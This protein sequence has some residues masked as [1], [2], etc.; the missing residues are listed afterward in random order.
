L[1]FQWSASQY[2]SPR[3]SLERYRSRKDSSKDIFHINSVDKDDQGNYI[4]LF[5]YLQ[6]IVCV[7]P[8]GDVLWT[9]GGKRNSFYDLSSGAATRI[10][11]EHRAK[12]QP[13]NI[14]N[15]FE[16]D[17]PDRRASHAA[18]HQGVRIA[19]D[20]DNITAVLI[21]ESANSSATFVPTHSQYSPRPTSTGGA[22]AGSSKHS[23]PYTESSPGNVICDAALGVYETDKHNSYRKFKGKWTG[24]P[25]RRPDVAI[26]NGFTDMNVYVSWNGATDV[27]HWRVESAG[28]RPGETMIDLQHRGHDSFAPL[29]TVPRAGFET[30][31]QTKTSSRYVRVVGLDDKHV[32]LGSSIID[33][34]TNII[35][36]VS[37]NAPSF[38]QLSTLSGLPCRTRVDL[39]RPKY[40]LSR[41][42]CIPCHSPAC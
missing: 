40:H 7:S 24:R 25:K 1:V 14:M 33:T 39:P 31:I 10:T 16:T 9:L 38:L 4:I 5:R 23:A 26:R 37:D 42:H 28:D 30:R 12:W 13:G 21:Q 32:P 35:V 3:E 11:T 36:M 34:K 2:F 18:H 19:L 6:A 29:V 41:R 22:F 20:P 27:R 8:Y 15:L 17:A